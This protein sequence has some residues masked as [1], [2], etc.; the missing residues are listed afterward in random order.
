VKFDRIAAGMGPPASYD[1]NLLDIYSPGVTVTG[2]SFDTSSPANYNDVAIYV[3]NDD[4]TIEDC[5]FT[6]DHIGRDPDYAI[7]TDHTVYGLEI[8]GCSFEGSSGI[9]IYDD[10][11]SGS[12][13]PADTM[14]ISNNTFDGL[15]KAIVLFGTYA[16]IYGNVIQ[17]STVNNPDDFESGAIELYGPGA[18][19]I[20]SNTIKDNNGFALFAALDD[21]GDVIF[22]GNN[23][24]GNEM[25]VLNV[26][27][28][29]DCELNYWGAASGPIGYTLIG[30]SVEY[31]PF[32]TVA[33][34]SAFAYWGGPLPNS[35]TPA[36]FS[37]FLIT[38]YDGEG[39]IVGQTLSG[40]PQEVEPPFPA[41]AYFDVYTSEPTVD[42]VMQVNLYAP[43]L[44]AASNVYYWSGAA[45]GWVACS[46]QAL[47]GSG[48]YVWF[49]VA[50]A[51][52][53]GIL[54]E[55]TSPA[56]DEMCNTSFVIVDGIAPPAEPFELS[57]PATGGTTGLS[58]IPFT[59][60]SVP[61]ATG[62]KIVIWTTDPAAPVVEQET[63]SPS[64][65]A[66]SLPAG[67]YFWQVFAMQG[68]NVI[69]ESQV[70]SF[71]AQAPPT[72]TT[73]PPPITI[74]PG[75]TTSIVLPT[76]TSTIITVPPPVEEVTNPVWIWVIIG[77]G[78]VLVIVVI[79]LI[80]RTRRTS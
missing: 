19:S 66:G 27:A 43:G 31:E 46:D 60:P 18:V 67:S 76:P 40:N 16:N 61:G 5:T 29:L 11:G 59:W 50:N 49:K 74:P 28:E 38:G 37:G 70:G 33:S 39:K 63:T 30:D 53:M 7:A 54:S 80:V 25:N 62:Y 32:L 24:T 48:A 78:A 13:D 3:G 22:S 72:T 41:I 8:T 42:G 56:P 73:A 71:V 44:T 75:T 17:N 35:P 64:F 34:E 47:S 51:S 58:N 14:T 79:V 36:K 15:E 9:G 52:E 68:E 21:P 6:V 69:G 2:C 57:G 23:I 20:F 4:V 12:Y 10:Y 45:S 77:I 1:E 65:M 26:G 55:E